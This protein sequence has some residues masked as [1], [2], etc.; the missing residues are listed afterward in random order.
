MIKAILFDMDGVL[1]EARDWHYEALN[2]ALALFGYNINYSD[3]IT[4]FDG[5]PTSEKLKKLTVERALPEALHSFINEMKQQ[6]TIEY[7]FKYCRPCFIHEY[8]LSSLKS[9]GY[10]MAC[11]SNSIRKTM[12]LMLSYSKLEQYLDLMLSNQDVAKSKPDPEIYLSAM[13]KLE[14]SPNE[15]LIVEDNENGVK[16]A[17]ASGAYLL[18]VQNTNEVTYNNIMQQINLVQGM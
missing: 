5:L 15:C 10:K 17:I 9:H 8:A 7:I 18:K 14:V 16:A 12:D 1:I 2:K 13:N 6:Y 11:C 4:N 3:H